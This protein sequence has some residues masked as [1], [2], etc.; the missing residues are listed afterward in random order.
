ML[1]RIVL[2]VLF[3]VQMPQKRLEPK[4]CHIGGAKIPFPSKVVLNSTFFNI[5]LQTI[6]TNR[7]G[8]FRILFPKCQIGTLKWRL[9]RIFPKS[10]HKLSSDGSS[11][12]SMLGLIVRKLRCLLY[13]A[14]AV[15]Q[16]AEE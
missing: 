4:S 3:K 15:E 10:R 12:L 7:D 11:P 6:K 5:S 13:P 8:K 1:K 16:T 14:I 2:L 9:N